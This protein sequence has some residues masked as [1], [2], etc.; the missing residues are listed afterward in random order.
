MG[1]F[2]VEDTQREFMA[3]KNENKLLYKALETMMRE[4]NRLRERLN[5]ETHIQMG[6]PHEEQTETNTK[7]SWEK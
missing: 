6:S 2:I 4:N 3:M 5:D 7:L 1:V